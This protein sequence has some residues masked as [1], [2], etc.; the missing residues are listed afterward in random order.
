MLYQ[1]AMK[2]LRL[3]G[4]RWNRCSTTQLGSCSV[5]LYLLWTFVLTTLSAEL[6]KYFVYLLQMVKVIKEFR[7]QNAALKSKCEN[8]DVALVKL[9]EEVMHVLLCK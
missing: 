6:N 8:S 3:T 7:K 9:I 2:P 4:G 1:K 5:P